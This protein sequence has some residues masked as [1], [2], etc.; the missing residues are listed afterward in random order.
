[1]NLLILLI[2]IRGKNDSQTFAI[3]T[4]MQLTY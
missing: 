2:R 3:K 4:Q 1:M